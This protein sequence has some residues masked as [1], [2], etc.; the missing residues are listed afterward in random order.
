MKL[1]WFRA[2]TLAPRVPLPRPG[3]WLVIALGTLAVAVVVLAAPSR[4][5]PLAALVPAH[6]FVAAAVG[7][8]AI[9][10]ARRFLYARLAARPGPIEITSFSGSPPADSGMR[11]SDLLAEFRRTLAEMSLSAP[12][13]VPGEPVSRT[14]VDD[15]RTAFDKDRSAFVTAVL[16]VLSLLCVRQ[17][18]AVSVQVLSSN[19]GRAGLSVHV[20]RLPSGR[21]DVETV[22]ADDWRSAAQRAAHVVGAFLVPRSRLSRRSPWR[23]WHGVRMPSELFHQTQVAAKAIRERRYERALDALHRALHEDPQNPYLRIDLGQVQEQVGL[24]LDAAAT[25]AD[26]IAVESWFDGRLWRR[27]RRILTDGTTGAPPTRL[28]GR[29]NGRD[30]LLIARYRVVTRLGAAGQLHQQWMGPDG[31]PRNRRRRSEREALKLRLR[32]WLNSYAVLYERENRWLDRGDATGPL[33]DRVTAYERQDDPRLLV[34]LFQFIGRHEA[35]ALAD[36]YRWSRVRRV[37]GLAVNQT[38]VHLLAL[39]ATLHEQQ[40]R[41]A[42]HPDQTAGWWPVENPERLDGRIARRLYRKPS[43]ARSWKEYYNAACITAVAVPGATDE[44]DRR[45]LALQAVR[46][47][48]RAVR[49]TDSG[50]VSRYSQWLAT[51]DRDLDGVRG[52]FPFQ[53]FLDRY[54]PAPDPRPPRPGSELIP[55]L[56]SLHTARLLMSWCDRRA[57]FWERDPD[58]GTVPGLHVAELRMES[59]A[60]ALT[61]EY[62]RDDRHWQTRMTLLDAA[63]AFCRRVGL[64]PVEDTFPRFADDARV[65]E[66]ADDPEELRRMNGGA[67]AYLRA[68]VIRPRTRCLD[69]L[70]TTVADRLDLLAST[71]PD[72]HSCCAFWRGL[73][74]SLREGLGIPEVRHHGVSSPPRE[75]MDPPSEGELQE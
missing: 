27:L 55:V 9:D 1:R 14:V 75:P 15:V 41:H 33:V 30:A 54:L 66:L 38:A 35:E 63:D 48:E 45:I 57:E 3:R 72:R 34:H 10:P 56:M 17:A 58:D 8:L 12:E 59:P 51:G 19:D 7:L 11:R 28:G 21:G 73:G 16:L 44:R 13:P 40:A 23:A 62:V 22:W 47:L 67:D 46:H 39:G 29:R 60:V 50:Y 71:S 69:D 6:Q 42:L 4:Y 20:S 25:Y 65:A 49:S 61:L 68:T 53:D 2:P 52:T 26:V 74:Q 43:F 36:D 24:H 32:V 37:P 31:G 5:P 18:Y 64:P 70:V